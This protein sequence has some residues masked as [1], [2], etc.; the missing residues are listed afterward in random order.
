MASLIQLNRLF[1]FDDLIAHYGGPRSLW[2][3]LRPHL[4]GFCTH[5]GVPIYL[6]SEVDDFL[7]AVRG[8]IH[9]NSPRHRVPEFGSLVEK[10][11]EQP[12]YVTVAQAQRCFLGGMRSLR[13]WYRMAETGKITHHR[14]GDS[15]LF[16]TQDIEDYIAKSRKEDHPDERNIEQASPRSI[17]LPVPPPVQPRPR[18][19][20]EDDPLRFQFFPRR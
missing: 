1:S 12:E 3:K 18:C 16:R 9:A 7:N 5:D 8:G 10:T 2:E 6:E 20:P 14:V 17:P 11:E 19:K 15:I 13:W 4:P